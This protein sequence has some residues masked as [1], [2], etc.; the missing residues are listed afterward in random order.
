MHREFSIAG[1]TSV[2]LFHGWNL[3]GERSERKANGSRECAPDDKLRDTHEFA[4]LE[5][6]SF[7]GL[8]LSYVLAAQRKN[9]LLRRFRF[10]SLSDGGQVA[11]RN[12]GLAL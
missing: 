2:L 5:M 3:P 12:D 9:G 11:P 6:M 8:N 4:S 7:A 10:R 1:C